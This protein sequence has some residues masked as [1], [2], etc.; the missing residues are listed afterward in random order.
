[1]A[2]KTEMS[3]AEGFTVGASKVEEAKKKGTMHKVFDWDR[4]VK[5]IKD[6]LKEHK[7]LKAEAGLQCDW[8]HTSGVIFEDGKPVKDDY[9]YLASAWAVPTLIFTWDDEEQEDIECF[10]DASESRFTAGSSWD[11]ALIKELEA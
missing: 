5:L 11:E 3:F 2:K 9:T 8:A 4:A 7:D 1:M 6:N 10:V